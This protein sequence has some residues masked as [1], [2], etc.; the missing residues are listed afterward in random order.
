MSALIRAAKR[1]SSL[2]APAKD[3]RRGGTTSDGGGGEGGDE[4]FDDA[5]PSFAIALFEPGRDS[6]VAIALY[7]GST[8]DIEFAVV[9]CTHSSL[10][11]AINDVLDAAEL[12]SRPTA[13]CA[14]SLP[15]AARAALVSRC[16]GAPRAVPAVTFGAAAAS[17]ALARA[18]TAAWL[19]VN[20]AKL[21]AEALLW[22][23]AGGGGAFGPHAPSAAGSTSCFA[24][25]VGAD[26]LAARVV[27][28]LLSFLLAEGVL[29]AG[30]RAGAGEGGGGGG[31][32]DG[33]NGDEPAGFGDAGGE[34]RP[35]SPD[36]TTTATPRALRTI[37]LPGTVRV[38][39]QKGHMRVDGLTLAA[40]GVF[41]GD[42]GGGGGQWDRDAFCLFGLLDRT[43]SA[44]GKRTLGSWLRRPL[45]DIAAISARHDAVAFFLSAR[46]SA[47]GAFD[48]LR[49]ALGHVR[50][51]PRILFRMKS[52]RA[53]ARDWSSL[54]ESLRALD[55]ARGAID[56]LGV[57]VG[58]PPQLVADA[59]ANI[60]T[61]I[62]AVRTTL[63]RVVDWRATRTAGRVVVR[64]GLDAALDEYRQ[65]EADL[66]PRLTLLA[67]DERARHPWLMAQTFS[68]QYFPRLGVLAV[69]GK[70]LIR[71]GG[72]TPN[73]ERESASSQT[74]M[75]TPQQ[76]QMTQKQLKQQPH[77]TDTASLPPPPT[78]PPVPH[79][80][81]PHFESARD[82]YYKTEASMALDGFFGDPAS[83]VADLERGLVRQLEDNVLGVHERAL[84]SAASR[85]GELDALTTL[86]DAAAD[87]R[88]VRPTL[89][90]DSVLFVRGARHALAQIAVAATG[91]A[92][93][94]NDIALAPGRLGTG[95]VALV[96]GPNASGKSVFLK[97]V[98]LLCVLAQAGSFVPAD[99]AV[100]GIV[101][102]LYARLASV[103]SAGGSVAGGAAA[104]SAF[105][106]D[107][108][109]VGAAL[110][111]ATSRSLLLIDEWGK[112]TDAADGAALLAATVRELARRDPPP[113]AVVTTHFREVFDAG[114]LGGEGGEPPLNVTFFHMKC[115][116]RGG[117]EGGAG[118]R[119]GA[120]AAG[121]G[122][123]GVTGDDEGDGAW[124]GA[125][126]GAGARAGAGAATNSTANND[127]NDTNSDADSDDGGGEPAVVPLFTLERGVALTSHGIACARIARLPRSVIARARTVAAAVA[128]RT[129]VPRPPPCVSDAPV[130]AAANAASAAAA[131]AAAT[132]ILSHVAWESEGAWD[133]SAGGPLHELLE[134][135]LRARGEA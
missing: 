88:F 10:V 71:G 82:I 17:S 129:A 68:Y 66:P 108:A 13:L 35:R 120:G 76:S 54:E 42:G 125:G 87:Y 121:A 104:A 81:V 127:G 134:L 92:Y 34:P 33:G 21:R 117:A 107:A 1:R 91:S 115:A 25:L 97:T 63:E 59:G 62:D 37:V 27:G 32:I 126:A 51:L 38:L 65:V 12:D 131:A 119:A 106:L 36:M 8:G 111:H 102:A 93:V 19:A 114:L 105:G 95:P 14:G 48:S 133:G 128:A 69:V 77:R 2:P 84:L 78:P 86:A 7:R 60:G 116:T 39:A 11:A 46:A 100:I 109:Q 130:A 99:A 6:R 53:G 56:A 24:S 45:T 4:P 96:T 89:T 26:E 135:V 22:V 90:D 98:G 67:D 61:D 23:P 28:G 73:T 29:G 18:T 9:P 41:V 112:G 58:E 101:D 103:E 123:A 44:A 47:P 122:G 72:G 70:S 49:R 118:E 64:A 43:A 5:P 52:F 20:R 31:V 40:L 94:A 30:A 75:R 79:S 50:D 74:Q 85:A 110:A 124:A 55:T 57:A 83:V 113:R 15:D 80:W 3:K 132:L 16:A